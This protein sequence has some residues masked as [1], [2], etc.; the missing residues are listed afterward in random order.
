AESH[1]D[2]DGAVEL[3][4]RRLD[5]QFCSFQRAV[6]LVGLDELGGGLVCLASLRHGA[7]S[8]LAIDQHRGT[9]VPLIGSTAVSGLRTP[10]FGVLPRGFSRLNQSVTVMPIDRAVP[11][12]IL[13][14]WSTS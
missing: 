10:A 3:R 14:A 13:A 2:L 5:G 6:D 4:G 7:Y 12:M 11:A 8:Y 9:S 1:R